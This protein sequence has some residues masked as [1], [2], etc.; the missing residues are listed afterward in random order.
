M[1]IRAISKHEFDRI[2]RDSKLD[3]ANIE[4]KTDFWLISINPAPEMMMDAYLNSHSME[5][6]FKKDHPQLLKLFF[7]DVVADTPYT[8]L[9]S[10]K[11]TIART[12]TEDQA[13]ITLNFL[14]KMSGHAGTLLVHC[15]MG[16]SRSVAIAHFAAELLGQD[17]KEIYENENQI[18]N[19]TVLNLLRQAREKK[20]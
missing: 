16:K 6:Y 10:K 19:K 14:E 13:N 15:T 2:M 9:G 18:P 5:P 1:K 7:D 20:N 17:T 11:S 12:M 8:V 4:Q 3:D